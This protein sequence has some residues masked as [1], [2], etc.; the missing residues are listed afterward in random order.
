METLNSRSSYSD[1]VTTSVFVLGSTV[2][3]Y[4]YGLNY[5]N[6]LTPTL[7][8]SESASAEPQSPRVFGGQQLLRITCVCVCVCVDGNVTFKNSCSTE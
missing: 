7:N 4:I 1:C 6:P 3:P 2:P 5:R 8:R